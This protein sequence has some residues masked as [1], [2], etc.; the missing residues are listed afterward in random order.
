MI[1]GIEH[2]AI[3][4]ANPRALADWYVATLGFTINYDSGRTV[5]VKAPDGAM[6]EILTAEG[7]RSG[8]TLKT[9]G[10]R[11]IAL[12]AGGIDEEYVRLKNL[13]VHLLG[14]PSEAKGV[15]TLY[16]ADPDGNYLHLIERQSPL[17]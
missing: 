5:F 7:D 13:G 16:F 11:H 4:A 3:A 10:L 2:V 15:K 14:E 6:I 8:Q 1:Q 17:P 12:S 9:P